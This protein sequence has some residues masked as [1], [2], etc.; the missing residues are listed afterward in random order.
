MTN[1]SKRAISKKVSKQIKK[2]IA[3][4]FSPERSVEDTMHILNELLTDSEYI[5]L[6][7][8]LLIITLL[9]KGIPQ[10]HIANLMD[11]TPVTVHAWKSRLSK[12]KLSFIEDIICEPTMME[13][14][15]EAVDAVLTLGG[16]VPHRVGYRNYSSKIGSNKSTK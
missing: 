15:D 7:K 3:H 12:K 4:I 6:S 11:V 2:E 16:Y 9:R 5:M 14:L 13:K 8:R 10:S 1:V